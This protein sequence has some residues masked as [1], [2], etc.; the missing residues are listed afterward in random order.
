MNT[1]AGNAPSEGSGLTGLR[2]I[3]T[4]GAGGIGRAVAD[5]LIAQGS[6]VHICDVS[7]EVPAD[8]AAA[9]P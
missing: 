1:L 8:F 6:K 7:D 2:V 5:T 4:A 3:V 9:H